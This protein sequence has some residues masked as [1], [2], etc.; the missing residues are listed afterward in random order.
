MRWPMIL[1][2]ISVAIFDEHT[3]LTPLETD[4]AS[5]LHAALVAA[6]VC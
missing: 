3:R 6:A 5:S 4:G 1:L 2:A